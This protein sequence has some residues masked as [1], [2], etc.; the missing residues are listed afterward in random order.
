MS[1]SAL[2]KYVT[3]LKKKDLEIQVLDLYE[4]FPQVKTYYDFVFNPK[5]DKLIGDAK[6]R[7]SREYFPIKRKRP[8]ARRSVAQKLIKKFTTLGM[9]PFLLAELMLFNLE[10]A[11]R[12]S[13][14]RKVDATFYKSMLRSY[15]EVVSHIALNG[16]KG[17]FGERMEEISAQAKAQDWDNAEAFERVFEA[18]E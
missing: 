2:K 13:A 3:G 4:R 14:R 1:K 15:T 16:L 7:I 18:L 8:K 9:D 5:E 11:Q 6:A 17:E 12:Y 10:T